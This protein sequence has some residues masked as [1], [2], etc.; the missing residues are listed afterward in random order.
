MASVGEI[1]RRERSRQGLDLGSIAQ[2]T[3]IKQQFLEAL[4]KDDYESLPGRFFV[5]AF[6]NQY[7]DWLGVNGPEMQAA[8]ERQ[9]PAVH[10]PG[11][12]V[13]PNAAGEFSISPH[14]PDKPAVD[15]LPEGTA[16]ILNAKKLAS[17]VVMLAMVIVACGT[18][19]WLWQR[20]QI[21]STSAVGMPNPLESSRKQPAPPLVSN[22]VSP[23]VAQPVIHEVKPPEPTL[24]A[25]AAPA[26]STESTVPGGKINLVLTA[27]EDVWIRVTADNRIVAERL[28]VNGES[29]TAA[30]ND[31]AKIL[32]GNAGG[33]D[34]RFNGANIGS[35]GPR[36]QIRTVDFT[37]E[38]YNVTEPVRE[39]KK[40]A[41]S[42]EPETGQE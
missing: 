11:G 19:F 21:S 32:M 34:I 33:L 39:P 7:A 41:D 23:P 10:S 2:Q 31:N 38:K 40:A 27:R 26:P 12:G 15:P 20:S 16:S 13:P 18:A 22:T 30:A 14:F 5:R 35:V 42:Q 8:I 24:L 36:G 28:M 29:H 17:S 9:L 4:E 25:S 1:L 37:P 6:T 3:R